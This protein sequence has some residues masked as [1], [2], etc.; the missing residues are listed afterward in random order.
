MPIHPLE[1]H[2]G[3][4]CMSIPRLDFNFNIWEF[5]GCSK[6]R[7][8]S[9]CAHFLASPPAIF[10]LFSF[11]GARGTKRSHLGHGKELQEK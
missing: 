7:S 9:P 10:L 2:E 6:G 4:E 3:K 5:D 1:Q 11:S 8:F